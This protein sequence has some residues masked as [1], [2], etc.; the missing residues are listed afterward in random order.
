[1][2]DYKITEQGIPEF[3]VEDGLRLLRKIEQC[4]SDAAKLVLLRQFAERIIASHCKVE[5]PQKDQ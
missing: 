2:S 1:M 4:T 3:T 5:T